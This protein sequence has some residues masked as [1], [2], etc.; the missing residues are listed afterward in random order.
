MSDR[1]SEAFF[2]KLLPHSRLITFSKGEVVFA[3]GIETSSIHFLVKGRIAIYSRGE[4]II[5]L[6]RKGD[7]FGELNALNDQPVSITAIAESGSCLICRVQASLL[8]DFKNDGEDQ[9]AYEFLKI[10]ASGLAD[11]LKQTISK[12]RQNEIVNR[13]LE[14]SKT[15]LKK[16]LRESRAARNKLQSS[17]ERFKALFHHAADAM[18]I[19]TLQGDIIDANREACESLGYELE[20]FKAL[21]ISEISPEDCTETV[22]RHYA[23]L[24]EQHKTI[25]ETEHLTKS[26]MRK[27]VEIS[28][29]LIEIEFQPFVF[30]VVRDIS[31][32]QEMEAELRQ[33]NNHLLEQTTRAKELMLQAEVANATKSQFLANMSHEI[34]TPM[35]GIIGMSE[36]LAETELN[37][38]QRELTE[39]IRSSSGALLTVINDILDYSKIEAGK[40]ELEKIEFDLRDTVEKAVDLLAIKTA[41]KKLDLNC[42]VAKDLPSILIG[43]PGRIR[44]VLLNLINNALKFTTEGEIF[45]EVSLVD[46]QPDHVRVRFSVKDTG[47]GIPRTR[48][49]RLFKSFSQ[50]D[51]STT[52]RFGGTGLGLAIS[53]QLTELMG[54][55]IGVDSE[56]GRGSTFWFTARFGVVDNPPENLTKDLSIARK[57]LI[58]D[59]CISTRKVLR[60]YMEWVGVQCYEVQ[61]ID[62]IEPEWYDFMLVSIEAIKERSEKAAGSMEEVIKQLAKPVVLLT[63]KGNRSGARLAQSQCIVDYLV[64]PIKQKTLYTKILKAVGLFIDARMD[65]DKEPDKK[66]T[67]PVEQRENVSILL[68]EDNQINQKVAVRV[69]NKLGFQC[70]IASNGKEV[71][72]MLA[73]HPYDVILMDCQMPEMDGFEA[74]ESIRNAEQGS[75]RR[76]SIIA[77]TANAMEGDREKCLAVGMDDYVSKPIDREKL[78]AAIENQLIRQGRILDHSKP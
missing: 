40:L 39:A 60:D 75:D 1:V 51:V 62:N 28:A 34:R 47:I 41:E 22:S 48:M 20:E 26:G 50:V 76:I 57:A 37:D 30:S 23:A 43:D 72:Q 7:I 11:K 66:L 6:S 33:V 3:E 36:L 17:E 38:E 5:K 2:E 18:Y 16:A 52:R 73:D 29:Q 64:K 21:N 56:E 71:L 31:L 67:V 54:G 78:V 9:A 24:Q 12:A 42:L 19:H 46:L 15:S 25:F 32:R 27:P 59:P 53:K 61:A 77:M 49:D 74:T 65:T 13:H 35:N 69:L 68:A 44:Q 63:T 70:D 14:Q 10:L 55:S 8:E 45:V 58:V 4:L